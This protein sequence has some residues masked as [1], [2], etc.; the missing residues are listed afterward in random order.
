MQR[1]GLLSKV[2]KNKWFPVLSASQMT[3]LRPLKL[4]QKYTLHTTLEHWDE[5]WYVI[6]QRFEH[7]GKTYAIGRV[8]GLFRDKQGTVSCDKVL[9]HIECVQNI[10]SPAL[11]SETAMWIAFLEKTTEAH[12]NSSKKN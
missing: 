11:S 7:H 10:S 1:V 9:E 12:R 2:I 3:F 4:F 8:R 6:T 5:K